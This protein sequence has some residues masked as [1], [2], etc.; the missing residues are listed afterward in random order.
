[1]DGL[2]QPV[3]Q[4]M[5]GAGFFYNLTGFNGGF[6]QALP[7]RALGSYGSRKRRASVS[8]R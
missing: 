3:S 2:N 8:H 7:D 5:L 6:H 4:K 1:M